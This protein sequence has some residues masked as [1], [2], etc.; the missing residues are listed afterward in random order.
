M[1]QLNNSE[2]V[3]RGLAS[4]LMEIWRRRMTQRERVGRTLQVIETLPVGARR[5]LVLVR[6]GEE[7][8]LVGGGLESI[9]TMV[10]VEGAAL[11]Q[12]AMRCE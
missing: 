8:F 9:Q 2:G 3:R 4:W 1:T 11:Q 7:Y 12:E 5:Q 10:K 6:C